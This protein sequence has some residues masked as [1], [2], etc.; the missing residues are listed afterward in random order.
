MAVVAV[1]AGVTA[2]QTDAQLDASDRP[3]DR[4]FRVAPYVLLAV[5]TLL[6]T[7]SGDVI[8]HRSAAYRLGTIAGPGWPPAGCCGWSPCTRP[9]PGGAG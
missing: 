4:A 3:L 9:G 6:A 7:I 8:E 5:S 2:P 1:V